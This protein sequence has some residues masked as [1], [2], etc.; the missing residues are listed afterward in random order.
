M[1][2]VFLQLHFLLL[3]VIKAKKQKAHLLRDGLFEAVRA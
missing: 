3:L 2:T 1:V